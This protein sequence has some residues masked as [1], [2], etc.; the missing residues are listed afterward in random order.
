MSSQSR[1]TRRAVILGS[2]GVLVA[3][4]LLTVQS[5]AAS[6]S[7]IKVSTSSIKVADGRVFTATNHLVQPSK[8][9]L[10]KER[11][12][13]RGALNGTDPA[14]KSFVTSEGK[15]R[16]EYLVVWAGD[17]NA[18]DEGSATIAHGQS[19][20]PVTANNNVA[21][22]SAGPDFL[23]VVDATKGLP[24][25]G[26]VVNTITTSPVVENEPHHMQYVWHK[27]E[28]IYAG[29]LFTAVTYVF[30]VKKLP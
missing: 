3:A 11:E 13:V 20:N 1:T 16:H 15:I 22:E 7:D 17:R 29:G 28:K 9:I 8:A 27:G 4:G 23:A 2:A 30:D 18:G 14:A 21:D 6:A 10:A 26:K 19:V 5:S 12:L 25:Y 24:T